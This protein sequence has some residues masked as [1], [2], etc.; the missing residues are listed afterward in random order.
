MMFIYKI[1]STLA[2]LVALPTFAIYSLVTGKKRRGL[3]HHFGL[4]PT[5][6]AHGNKT[7]WLH[8]LSLGEVNAA[9]PVLKRVREE[10]P[11]IRIVVSVTTDSGYDRARKNM[12]FADQIIFHPLDCWPF[13]ALA[14]SRIQPDLFVVTDT[15]FWPGL[16]NILSQRKTP[17]IL[18]NG[19]LSKKSIRR[20]KAF[21]SLV[22][23]MFNNFD[24]L[25]MQN[26]QSR[27]AV[28]EIG[29]DPS[30]VRVIGD[31]KMD[32]L[33][34]VP[35]H[36]RGRIRGKLGISED[37]LVWV[38]GSTHQGEENII[39]DAYQK[40]KTLYKNLKLIIAPRRLERIQGVENLITGIKIS[41]VR[42]SKI[43]EGE[44]RSVNVILLDS[45]GELADIYS[46]ADV[47]FVGRSLISP[48]GGHS[49]LEPVT[50]GKVVL[51]GPYVENIQETADELGKLGVA[52]TVK[53]ANEMASTID[54]LLSNE[55]R[56]Q[57][58]SQ[59]ALAYNTY[60]E[61]ETPSHQMADI[62]KG[63]L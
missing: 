53:D 26:Q 48:G 40:L 63:Y 49:L 43:Q 38:A 42:R 7:L 18:F 3:A 36:D 58:L 32:A 24:L 31:T 12:P 27:S 14:V 9:E 8:A 20:Y 5:N 28:V 29:V 44:N 33:D 62:I 11:E 1:L 55:T 22:L 34:P 6:H 46:I 15:G 56:L 41:F 51:H 35:H 61:Q 10:A 47:A 16:L 54:D 23:L 59:K 50:Q 21:G 17:M 37:D 39:L 57:E 13:A 2:A 25:Y 60:E 30:R 45:M 4:A 19:R 52:I